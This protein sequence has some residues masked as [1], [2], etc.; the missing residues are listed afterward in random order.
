MSERGRWG[1]GRLG[2]IWLWCCFGFWQIGSNNAER[3][4]H[5]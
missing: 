2:Q 4:F 5:L 1:E 3:D